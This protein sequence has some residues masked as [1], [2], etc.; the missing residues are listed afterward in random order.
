MDLP[1]R[2]ESNYMINIICKLNKTIYGLK[3]SPQ[4]WFSKLYQTMIK[5]G[6]KKSNG[7]DTISNKEVIYVIYV[8]DIIITKDD[9][10][11][12][13]QLKS[14]L[15]SDFEIRDLGMSR[16]FLGIELVIH[17]LKSFLLRKCI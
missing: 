2:Y 11:V 17:H 10:I 14:Q 3:Q 7:D 5:F 1:P 6:Y 16:Y 8:D 15:E 13:L 9:H 12:I 4:A